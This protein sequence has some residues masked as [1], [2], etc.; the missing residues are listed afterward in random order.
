M[1]AALSERR[2]RSPRSF[3]HESFSVAPQGA[4][5]TVTRSLVTA[6]QWVRERPAGRPVH[7]LLRRGERGNRERRACML[8][9]ACLYCT[10]PT[11]AD[12]F[13]MISCVCVCAR[14]TKRGGWWMWWMKGDDVSRIGRDG[15]SSRQDLLAISGPVRPSLLVTPRCQSPVV[16]IATQ[17][18]RDRYHCSIAVRPI[19]P[20]AFH[21]ATCTRTR[22][23]ASLFWRHCSS[24]NT[25]PRAKF[26]DITNTITLEKGNDT[27]RSE[28]NKLHHGIFI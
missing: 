28:R 13:A 18:I 20:R 17:S 1:H 2:L 22:H 25:Y 16:V 26:H 5:A 11:D 14:S 6:L 24:L 8:L 10:L 23:R 15:R 27:R 4:L 7:V 9:H 3:R 12:R 19:I 21:A